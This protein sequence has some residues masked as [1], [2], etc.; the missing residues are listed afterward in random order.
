MSNPQSPIILVDGLTG[1]TVEA[2][3]FHE[4]NERHLRD[5][6]T[7]WRPWLERVGADHP[8]LPHQQSAHWDWRKK[9]NM[10]GDVLAFPSFAIEAKGETQGLMI[11]N[12]LASCRLSCQK[13]KPLVY[14]EFLETAPWNRTTL[15]KEPRFKRVGPVLMN[16][17]IQVSVQEQFGGRI[18]LHS[19]PQ[20]DGW[21][22]GKCR[23]EDLGPDGHK[24]NLRYFEMT[25][26]QA[27]TFLEKGE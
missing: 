6:E 27:R 1:Q 17:A 16:V 26:E 9:M 10:V 18:G 5:H 22:R 21:Y 12:T 19:L 15:T 20:A 23:M 2:V 7:L 3:L 24:Q 11:L 13:N 4:I 8:E 14:I 25:V